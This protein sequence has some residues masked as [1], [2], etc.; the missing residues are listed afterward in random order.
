MSGTIEASYGIQFFVYRFSDLNIYIGLILCL[1]ILFILNYRKELD[2]N[3]II[4]SKYYKNGYF[5]K[6]MEKVFKVSC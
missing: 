6:K 2:F 1:L 5:I 4:D 3:Q